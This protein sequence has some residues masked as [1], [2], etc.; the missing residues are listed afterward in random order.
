LAAARVKEPQKGT[1]IPLQK[2]WTD[3]P[4]K[5]TMRGTI[6]GLRAWS[7]LHILGIIY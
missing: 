3:K 4:D 2:N 1:K 7:Y 5:I 6:R